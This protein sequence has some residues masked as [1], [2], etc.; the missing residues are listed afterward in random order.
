MSLQNNNINTR[1]LPMHQQVIY[2]TITINFYNK[3]NLTNIV[4]KII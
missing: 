2:V 1:L 3:I 4:F